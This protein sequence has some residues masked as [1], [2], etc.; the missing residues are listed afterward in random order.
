MAKKSG[1]TTVYQVN[2]NLN[3]A[4]SVVNDCQSWIYWWY[5]TDNM[6]TEVIHTE[7]ITTNDHNQKCDKNNQK[8]NKYTKNIA[9]EGSL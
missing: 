5:P 4:C 8:K 2:E 1:P 6:P 3:N 7:N 9:D